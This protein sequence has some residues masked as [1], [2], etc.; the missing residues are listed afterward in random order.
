MTTSFPIDALFRNGVAAGTAATNLVFEVRERDDDSVDSAG[1]PHWCPADNVVE[2][3][4]ADRATDAEV[5]EP[6]EPEISTWQ[7]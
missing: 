4:A 2:E 6:A 7:R 5:E 3:F 1:F